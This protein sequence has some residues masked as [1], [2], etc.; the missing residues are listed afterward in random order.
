[1]GTYSEY[2]AVIKQTVAPLERKKRDE[3]FA[4]FG[5]AVEESGAHS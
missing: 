5:D 3:E 2:F 1:M 4:W